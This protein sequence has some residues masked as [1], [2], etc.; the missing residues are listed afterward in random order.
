MP[1][2]AFPSPPNHSV[3]ALTDEALADQV[4]NFVQTNSTVLANFAESVRTAGEFTKSDLAFMG[5]I[6]YAAVARQHEVSWAE[7]KMEGFEQGQSEARIALDAIRA[8][9]DGSYA[10]GFEVGLEQGRADANRANTANRL[11][12]LLERTLSRLEP[13][14]LAQPAAFAQP[15][16]ASAP[17]LS[18]VP[19]PGIHPNEPTL[20]GIFARPDPTSPANGN[21]PTQIGKA[22]RKPGQIPMPKFNGTRSNDEA[23]RF[24]RQM[25][26]YFES[27]RTL[28]H[29]EGTPKQKALIAASA[30]EGDAK[31]S[32]DTAW[33]NGQMPNAI[34]RE[35]RT[36]EEFKQWIKDTYR[37][38]LEN[39]QRWNLLK[40]VKLTKAGFN[41]YV[42]DFQERRADYPGDIPDDLMKHMFLTGLGHS[43]LKERWEVHPSK[44][45][46]LR[47]IIPILRLLENQI[48]NGEAVRG[49]GGGGVRA[50]PQSPPDDHGDPME[51]GAIIA[52]PNPPK[53]N[54]P[55]W[56][57]WCRKN[58]ACFSCGSKKHRSAECDRRKP[59]R[60]DGNGHSNDKEKS[61]AAKSKN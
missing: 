38:P 58:R 55:G 14:T 3:E 2:P 27:E 5:Q 40:S 61:S 4:L 50:A 49:G 47:E 13:P 35:P 36:W 22:Y 8:E 44:P 53:K 48:K 1:Q 21:L 57:G 32:W 60:S 33:R 6:A 59:A 23:N 11:E 37:V 7:G 52:A 45:E 28:S 24:L 15:S 17:G 25:E 42:S 19:T 26:L 31:T 46:T 39:E 10:R 34:E 56:N 30:L 43:K 41:K 12:E 16:T 18:T 51:L 20:S 29:I 54:S 9:A